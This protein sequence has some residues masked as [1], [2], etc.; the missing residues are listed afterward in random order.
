MSEIGL[1]RRGKQNEW[2]EQIFSRAEGTLAE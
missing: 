2:K 1:D